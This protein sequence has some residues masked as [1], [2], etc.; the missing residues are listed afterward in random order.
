[1][2][3]TMGTGIY[4][5]HKPDATSQPPSVLKFIVWHVGYM[6]VK[7]GRASQGN[8]AADD[9]ADETQTGVA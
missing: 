9:T 3:P 4:K 5:Q 8:G 7:G 1:M 2:Y 6:G